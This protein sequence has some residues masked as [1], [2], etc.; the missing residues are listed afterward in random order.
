[1]LRK[2]CDYIHGVP[3]RGYPDITGQGLI[4]LTGIWNSGIEV[5]EERYLPFNVEV[6]TVLSS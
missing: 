6:R 4:N 5:I 2:K 1:M 3:R